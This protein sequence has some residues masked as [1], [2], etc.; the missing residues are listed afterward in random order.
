MTEDKEPPDEA[1]PSQPEETVEYRM[2]CVVSEVIHVFSSP[3]PTSKARTTGGHVPPQLAPFKR[4][5]WVPVVEEGDGVITDSKFAGTPWL[6]ASEEWP[7]CPN[8]GRHIQL[9]LQLNLAQLPEAARGEYG[10]GLIQLFYCTNAEALCDSKCE[11]FFPFSRSVVVRLVAPEGEPNAAPAP[12]IKRAFPPRLI[13]GWRETDDYP[14]VDESAEL[15]VELERA[16]SEALEEA[17]YP[18]PGD[19]LAG[20][21]QWIQGIEYPDCPDCGET[22]RLVFQ[23]DSEDNIPFGFG[24]VGCSHITQ[25]A[26][27]KEQLGFGWACS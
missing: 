19:K 17:G 16:E 8:C 18:R 5:A 24:D 27:H 1:S 4:P 12:E 26:T 11:A 14:N 25:C 10:E 23:I 9:F 15:G 13:V 7:V 22:M 2:E 6:G 21:P 3:P 20:W